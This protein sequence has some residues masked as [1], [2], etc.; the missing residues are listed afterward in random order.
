MSSFL[1]KTPS[2]LQ[3]LQYQ[4]G[5][6]NKADSTALWRVVKS[7][8]Y[9]FT[10]TTIVTKG[11]YIEGLKAAGLALATEANRVALVFVLDSPGGQQLFSFLPEKVVSHMPRVLSYGFTCLNNWNN[12][13]NFKASALAT[14]IPFLLALGLDAP[15]LQV[16]GMIRA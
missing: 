13:L 12:K 3:P 10:V 16:Y 9:S 14:G 5:F 4:L 8:T 15:G 2:W 1:Y 6:V 11:N 7:M